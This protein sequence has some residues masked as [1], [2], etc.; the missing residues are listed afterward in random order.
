MGEVVTKREQ[1]YLDA[2][3]KYKTHCECGKRMEIPSW[4]K[5]NECSNKLVNS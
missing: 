3:A 2:A 1:R 5:C 4:K